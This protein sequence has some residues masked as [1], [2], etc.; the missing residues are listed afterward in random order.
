MSSPVEGSVP[1]EPHRTFSGNTAASPSPQAKE[2]PQRYKVLTPAEIAA[3]PPR[4]APGGCH[5]ANPHPPDMRTEAPDRTHT[6]CNPR[7]GGTPGIDSQG[8]LA[9]AAVT[10]P[11]PGVPRP[12][13]GRGN[14]GKIPAVP[15]RDISGIAGN[16]EAASLWCVRGGRHL[17]R[18]SRMYLRQ[19]RSSQCDTN[20]LE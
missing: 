8:G 12:H 15:Q 16:R 3:W 19:P 17:L 6:G 7:A 9:M 13:R 10:V 14:R 1:T 11:A 2:Q 5:R 20:R 4:A 18:N